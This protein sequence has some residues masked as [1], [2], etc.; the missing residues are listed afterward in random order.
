M[1]RRATPRPTVFAPPRTR[2]AS[3]SSPRT[4][5]RWPDCCS[6]SGQLSQHDARRRKLWLDSSRDLAHEWACTLPWRLPWRDGIVEGRVV[7]TYVCC[8]V[9]SFAHPQQ[10][11]MGQRIAASRASACKQVARQH[12]SARQQAAWVTDLRMKITRVPSGDTGHCTLD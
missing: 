9:D 8:V 6:R 5:S 12:G 10:Q 2:C 4:A 1:H 7:C 11:R 3:S